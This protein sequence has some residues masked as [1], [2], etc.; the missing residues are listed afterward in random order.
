MALGRRAHRPRPGARRRARG[1]PSR[2]PDGGR[3]SR[4]GRGGQT[5]PAPSLVP[6]V[7]EPRHRL[8]DVDGGTDVPRRVR[9]GGRR[10]HRPAAVGG[11]ALPRRHGRGPLHCGPRRRSRRRSFQRQDRAPLHCRRG[12][13]ERGL[14]ASARAGPRCPGHRRLGLL[15]RDPEPAGGRRRAERMARRARQPPR[16]RDEGLGLDRRGAL[17]AP[18]PRAVRGHPLPRRRPPRLRLGDRLR[19][20]GPRRPPERRVRGAARLRGARG[21]D[22][23]LR[24]PANRLPEPGD[25]DLRARADLHLHRVRELLAGAHQRRV[26]RAGAGVGGARADRGRPPR[27]RALDLQLPP[28]RKRDLLRV[29]VAAGPQPALG[30]SWPTWMRGAPAFATT[31]PT[32]TSSTGSRRAAT[33]TTW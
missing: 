18:R 7:G 3:R 4:G 21:H 15:L 25:G 30:V 10:G 26:P 24:A 27:V 11:A 8:G 22:P 16:P 31:R 28:G 5:P 9:G 14:T 17:L 6:G 29:A 32:P 19:V 2:R 12:L 20:H 33:A 23:L 13:R 1:G